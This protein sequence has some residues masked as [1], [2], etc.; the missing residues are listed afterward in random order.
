MRRALGVARGVA[1]ALALLAGAPSAR[2]Q[3]DPV[4][5]LERKVA[6]LEAKVTALESRAHDD[7][8]ARPQSRWLAPAAGRVYAVRSGVTIGGYGQALYENFDRLRENEQLAHRLDRV[9]LLRHGLYVGYRFDDQ[10]LINTAV[11]FEHGGVRN[12]AD[13]EGLTDLATAEVLGVATL[14][15]EVVIDFAYVEWSASPRFGLRGGLLL[16]PLGLTNEWHDPTVVLGAYRPEVEL[17]ILPTPWST[18]GLAA[19]GAFDSGLEWR[20]HVTEG[21]DADGFSAADGFRGGRQHGSNAIL[22]QPGLSARLDWHTPIGLMIGGAAYTGDSWQQFQPPGVTLEP[23]VTLYEG[24]LRW[25][26]HGLELRALHAQ[27]TLADASELSDE[28]ALVST[29]RLGES[30]LGSYV[31]GAFDVLTRIAP[32]SRWSVSPF[33]RWEHY[34]TQNDVPGGAENPAFERTVFTGGL[35]LRPHPSVM[36]EADRQWRRDEA[37]AAISQ[38]NLSLGYRF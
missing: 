10:L 23:R 14:S 9:S 25:S 20:V 17:R 12:R 19:F 11:A 7:T 18:L 21:L 13:V 38:W 34:D 5:V 30:F 29:N 22:T 26:G 31:E 36:L 35:A 3:E 32:G 6:A 4:E 8:T 2:A 24:H 27:G 1:V 28:L 37:T 15:G 16:A 33:A